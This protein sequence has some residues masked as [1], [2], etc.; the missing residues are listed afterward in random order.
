MRLFKEKDLNGLPAEK[1]LFIFLDFDGTLAP[2]RRKPCDVRLSGQ[3]KR[4]LVGLSRSSRCR[5]A[6][7]SG[8]RLTDI[9]SKISLPGAI[10]AADHGFVIKCSGRT[11]QPAAA[12]KTRA[13][14][15]KFRKAAEA[16]LKDCRGV[17]L[18]KKEITLSVHYR[19][20]SLKTVRKVRRLLY[21]LK[22]SP[23]FKREILVRQAKMS[24]EIR[25]AVDWD[26]GKAVLWLISRLKRSAPSGLPL[27]IGDDA[28]DEDAFV[29]LRRRG[30]T[31]RVGNAR[32]SAARFFVQNT[33]DVRKLLHSLL[34]RRVKG[35]KGAGVS[36]KIRINPCCSG[37]AC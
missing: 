17:E 33:S 18:E 19:R 14:V 3:M 16:L 9:E 22:E 8:R 11:F 12:L 24:C 28:T 25:P 7:I 29:A 15:K 10:Y 1:E 31:V 4:I 32:G 37:M 5:L 13:V 6:V 21:K 23:D 27:Y 35:A 30:M 34:R 26:K 2:I 36:G 20:A